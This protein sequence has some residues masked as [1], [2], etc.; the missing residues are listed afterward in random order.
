M[1]PGEDGRFGFGGACFPKD[2]N[3]FS[4][5]GNGTMSILDLV[6]EENN[7]IRS[8]YELDEREKV[9]KVVYKVS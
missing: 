4:A 8:Q 9:Q 1:V 3:A 6:I 7:K 2:T 5:F